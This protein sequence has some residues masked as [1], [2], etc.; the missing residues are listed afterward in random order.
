MGIIV[1]RKMMLTPLSVLHY[2]P[3]NC[4][5]VLLHT[6]KLYWILKSSSFLK[7]LA[8]TLQ[9]NIFIYPYTSDLQSV[10]IKTSLKSF[11][12]RTILGLDFS[13]N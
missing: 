7:Y 10:R 3:V 9:S 13:G 4:L 11:L 6:Y 8:I 2:I 1:E 12:E 5:E